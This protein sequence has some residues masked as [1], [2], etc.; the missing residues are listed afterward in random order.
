MLQKLPTST[1]GHCDSAITREHRHPSELCPLSM[2]HHLGRSPTPLPCPMSPPHSSGAC[3]IKT[4]APHRPARHRGWR[5][6]DSHARGGRAARASSACAT[7]PPRPFGHAAGPA[8]Q[9][10]FTLWAYKPGQAAGCKRW[11]RG[12]VLAQRR[13]NPFLFRIGLN[14]FRNSIKLPKIA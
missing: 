5:H 4:S 1:V 3:A 9:D 2:P 6:Y 12:P 7:G 11:D 14:I 10:T 13:L 8:W